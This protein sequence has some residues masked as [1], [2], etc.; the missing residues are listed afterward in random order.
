LAATE[1]SFVRSFHQQ[2]QPQTTINISHILVILCR[3]NHVK[4]CH[5]LCDCTVT[6]QKSKETGCTQMNK[7]YHTVS[8]SLSF[9]YRWDS[10]FEEHGN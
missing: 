2:L 10:C 5:T 1:V 8:T 4:I 9:F 3:L 7:I 6:A